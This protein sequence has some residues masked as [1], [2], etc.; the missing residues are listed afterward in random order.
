VGSPVIE[1]PKTITAGK[2]QGIQYTIKG[3]VQ[4]QMISY[5]HTTFE[6]SATFS[7]VLTW[8]L[9]SQFEKNKQMMDQVISSFV[10][11]K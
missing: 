1:G 10:S 2:L 8:T 5:I 3:S 7:Q 4:G 9:P 6:T 11:A